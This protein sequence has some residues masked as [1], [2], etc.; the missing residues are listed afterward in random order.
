MDTCRTKRFGG[1]GSV[2]ALVDR[3][4]T[5]NDVKKQLAQTQQVEKQDDMNGTASRLRAPRHWALSSA[6]EYQFRC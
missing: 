3:P 6:Q 4:Y 5:T 2:D 1:N